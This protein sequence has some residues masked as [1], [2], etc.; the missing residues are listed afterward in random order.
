MQ[1]LTCWEHSP[2]GSIFTLSLPINLSFPIP[3][4]R[5]STPPN[6]P[7]CCR[8]VTSCS[9]AARDDL[10]LHQLTH[11]PSSPPRVL[12]HFRKQKVK[13]YDRQQVLGALPFELRCA[14]LRHLYASAIHSVPLLH[15]MAD[16]DVFLTDVCLRLQ[17][18]STAA[19][20]FLYQRG[21]AGVGV[22]GGEKSYSEAPSDA[23]EPHTCP[24]GGPGRQ[25]HP[26]I[27][28]PEGW[29]ASSWHHQ[30]GF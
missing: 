6:P 30:G 18:Y 21:E 13:S 19:Q 4:C 12:N 24:C 26:A 1:P 14:I 27:L 3:L 29:N 5:T 8:P 2:R 25:H 9:A 10:Q 22:G 20:S 7:S 23:S 11:Q 28:A 16:D 17:A 15:R